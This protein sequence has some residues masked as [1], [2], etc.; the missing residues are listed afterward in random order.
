MHSQILLQQRQNT[1][2]WALPLSAPTTPDDHQQ[3]TFPYNDDKRNGLVWSTRNGLLRKLL[4]VVRHAFF[5][6]FC[7]EVQLSKRSENNSDNHGMKRILSFPWM[8][9]H[10]NC[11]ALFSLL[12]LLSSLVLLFLL[13]LSKVGGWSICGDKENYL[14]KTCGRNSAVL[15]AAFCFPR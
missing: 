6:L 7:S 5:L 1:Q 4:S 11:S 13:F 8:V 14:C 2:V 10:L 15:S 12:S 3:L 9:L